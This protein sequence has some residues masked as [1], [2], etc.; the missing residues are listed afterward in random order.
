MAAARATPAAGRGGRSARTGVAATGRLLRSVGGVGFIPV[1]GVW[2]VHVRVTAASAGRNPHGA[3]QREPRSVEPP[4]NEQSWGT[5]FGVHS[6]CN[7]EN[8]P[9]FDSL[10]SQPPTAALRSQRGTVCT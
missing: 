1:A 8:S 3:E 2:L 7:I 5:T 4:H 9:P 10:R 6:P